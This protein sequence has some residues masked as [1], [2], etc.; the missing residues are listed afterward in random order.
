MH[1]CTSHINTSSHREGERQSMVDAPNCCVELLQETFVLAVLKYMYLV[2]AA[3]PAALP[4]PIRI[5]E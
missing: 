4:K 2:T 1:T 3:C 5:K